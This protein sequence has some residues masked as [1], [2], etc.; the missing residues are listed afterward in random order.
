ML[1]KIRHSQL[2]FSLRPVLI[3][4]TLVCVMR[5]KRIR[6]C[7]NMIDTD[8][9]VKNLRA[10]W[11]KYEGYVIDGDEVLGKIERLLYHTGVMQE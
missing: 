4:V 2:S 9:L 1:M 10:I 6:G 8:K 3:V 5:L 7:D 11:T